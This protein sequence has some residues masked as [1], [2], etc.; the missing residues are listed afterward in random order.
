[1]YASQECLDVL[2]E[3]GAA[4]NH[5]LEVSAEGLGKFLFDFTQQDIVYKRHFQ[6]Q[7]HHG[8]VQ[9][10]EYSRLD[11]FFD[12]QRHGHYQLG[13]DRGEGFHNDAR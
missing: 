8:F 9:Q 2:V 4:D 10:R 12:Y 11:D 3:T 5:L 13:L 7:F 1:M 6:H